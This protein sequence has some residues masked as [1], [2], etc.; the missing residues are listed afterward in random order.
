MICKSCGK[1]FNGDGFLGLCE[2]CWQEEVKARK[3]H[4]ETE[5]KQKEYPKNKMSRTLE[6]YASVILAI[7]IIGGIVLSIELESL[8]PLIVAII[9]GI[10]EAFFHFSIAEIIQKL[11]NIEDNIRIIDGKHS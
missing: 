9:S 2:K 10:A 3:E 7:L 8:Y 5:D 11:Q 4:K 6:N 1:S